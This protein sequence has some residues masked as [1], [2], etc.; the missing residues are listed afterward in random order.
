MSDEIRYKGIT[1]GRELLNAIST[2]WE[3]ASRACKVN[4]H[5]EHKESLSQTKPMGVFL[6]CNSKN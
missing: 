2:G 3:I 4:E 5:P 6:N 1:N